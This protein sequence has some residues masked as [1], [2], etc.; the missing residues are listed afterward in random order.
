MQRGGGGKKKA[1]GK[2]VRGVQK[3]IAATT[4]STKEINFSNRVKPGGTKQKVKGGIREAEG[5]NETS[6][7]TVLRS[8]NGKGIFREREGKAPGGSLEKREKNP[9]KGQCREPGDWTPPHFPGFTHKTAH[10]KTNR[11]ICGPQKKWKS[12]K[13]NTHNV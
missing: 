13:K 7:S 9:S 8:M 3:G 4:Q 5:G 11:E 2:H 6:K 12:K 1:P 10:G